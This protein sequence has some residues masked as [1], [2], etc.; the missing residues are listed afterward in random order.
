MTEKELAEIEARA[1]AA[2]PGP[3]QT[4]KS[5]AGSSRAAGRREAGYIEPIA[6]GLCDDAF[7]RFV[8]I[9]NEES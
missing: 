9:N 8:S 4:C 5:P 1:N 2:T 6:A 7:G 3:W